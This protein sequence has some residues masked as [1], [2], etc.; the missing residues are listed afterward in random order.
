[1]STIRIECKTA[2]RSRSSRQGAICVSL[3]IA[4]FCA[5]W[6]GL[7]SEA[8]SSPGSAQE[9]PA[10]SLETYSNPEEHVDVD[11]HDANL[12]PMTPAAPIAISSVQKIAR[13]SHFYDAA[14]SDASSILQ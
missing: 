4:V 10:N 6:A 14:R 13:G 5:N 8:Q 1:M 12:M 9:K 3:A 2:N 7:R 11:Y